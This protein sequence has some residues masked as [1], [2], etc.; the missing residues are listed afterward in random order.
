MSEAEGLDHF[1]VAG[2]LSIRRLKLR[3]TAYLAVPHR[4]EHLRLIDSGQH[5]YLA[6]DDVDITTGWIYP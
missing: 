5:H 3:R 6:R 4:A 1:Q 2:L